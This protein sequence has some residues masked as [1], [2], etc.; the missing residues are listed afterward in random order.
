MQDLNMARAYRQYQDAIT[1][2]NRIKTRIEG[3]QSA[4]ALVEDSEQQAISAQLEEMQEEYRAA[5]E[6]ADELWY[7][8]TVGK[9]K[10]QATAPVVF[11]DAL[12]HKVF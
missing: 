8:S 12:G 2:V 9:T 6:Q 3:L 11:K 1:R 7:I 10:E 4:L 5:K